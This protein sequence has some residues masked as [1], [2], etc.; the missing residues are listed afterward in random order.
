MGTVYEDDISDS[1]LSS[2]CQTLIH[3]MINCPIE[4]TRTKSFRLLNGYISLFEDQTRFDLLKH[5]I[6]T[7]QYPSVTGL[8]ISRIQQ[9]VQANWPKVLFFYFIIIFNIIIIFFLIFFNYFNLI[10]FNIFNVFIFLL[11]LNFK[12]LCRQMK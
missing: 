6:V 3:F 5:I 1:F 4:K 7:C 9:E 10:I 8:I 12:F 11:F 2:L